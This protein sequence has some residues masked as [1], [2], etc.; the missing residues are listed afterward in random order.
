MHQLF[1]SSDQLVFLG[2]ITNVTILLQISIFIANF[3]LV[4]VEGDLYFVL[5]NKQ[6]S[7]FGNVCYFLCWLFIPQKK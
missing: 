2:L 6:D 5:V 3:I 4:V 7:S 1:H